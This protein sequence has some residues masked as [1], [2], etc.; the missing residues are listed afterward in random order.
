MR[1][2]QH[3]SLI[4]AVVLDRSNFVGKVACVQS[5]MNIPFTTSAAYSFVQN[6]WN[7]AGGFALVSHTAVC[8]S[9]TTDQ[10]AYWLVSGVGFTNAVKTANVQAKEVEL[11]G[12]LTHV[13]LTYGMWQPVRTRRS[14]ATIRNGTTKAG[15]SPSLKHASQAINPLV[16]MTEATATYGEP[17]S[18]MINGFPAGSC[19][20]DFDQTIDD[21]LG[22][23]DFNG[24]A[25]GFAT[26]IADFP[27]GIEDHDEADYDLGVALDSPGPTDRRR[28][29]VTSGFLGDLFNKAVSFFQKSERS[30]P[31]L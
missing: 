2:Y 17:H 25:Q 13:N 9:D 31:T 30:S 26:S 6:S 19:G 21:A 11:D 20:P 8:S 14:S 23:L 3:K 22:Y 10:R 5:G 27:P 15:S 7:S 28:E 16:R 4:S 12:A 1:P 24:S 18:P 29:L